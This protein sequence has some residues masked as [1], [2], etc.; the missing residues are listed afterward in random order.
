[1][2]SATASE[3]VFVFSSV[4]MKLSPSTT[5]FGDVSGFSSSVFIEP[6]PTAFADVSMFTTIAPMEP[7]PVPTASSMKNG[8]DL[9]CGVY[10]DDAPLQVHRVCHLLVE[11]EDCVLTKV[12]HTSVLVALVSRDW[13][14][15][16]KL[17]SC[18]LIKECALK[19]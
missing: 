15:K 5:A 16:V 14:V 19:F 6:S 8:S 18:G 17:V 1:M 9:C 2:E 7:S 13:T 10:C 12:T 11:M 4:F 3:D